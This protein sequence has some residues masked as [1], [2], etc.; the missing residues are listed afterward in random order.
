MKLC[1]QYVF[2]INTHIVLNDFHFD[3]KRGNLKSYFSVL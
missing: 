2:N 1:V 3:S